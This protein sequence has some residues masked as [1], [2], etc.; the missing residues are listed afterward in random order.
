MSSEQRALEQVHF[1]L[2]ERCQLRCKHCALAMAPPSKRQSE[3][4]TE[5]VFAIL[6]LTISKGILNVVLSGGEPLVRDDLVAIAHYTLSLGVTTCVIGTN[7]LYISPSV[8]SELAALQSEYPALQIRV[9]LDGASPDTHDWL[10]GEGSFHRTLQTLEQLVN[11]GV[12]IMGINTVIT[13]QNYQELDDL[14]CI[15]ETIGAQDLTLI[16]LVPLGRASSL[17]D[18]KLEEKEWQA[19]LELKCG[20]KGNSGL[21]INTRGPLDKTLLPKLGLRLA[22][23]K[24]DTMYVGATGS[25]FFCYPLQAHNCD[26]I[27]SSPPDQLWKRAERTEKWIIGQC[28]RCPIS[29]LCHGIVEDAVNDN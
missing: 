26:S 24:L 10:R 25:L 8:T 7:G 1:I 13:K 22:P 27:R 17:Q 18:V 3:L 2:T 15:A 16:D 6:R 21:R 12:S 5:E 9:S 23:F 28:K 4:S 11:A 29:V 14:T 19:I 20:W